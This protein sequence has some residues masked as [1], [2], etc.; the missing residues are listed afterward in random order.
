MLFYSFLGI[1]TQ[2]GKIESLCR[3]GTNIEHYPCLVKSGENIH[4]KGQAGCT[5]DHRPAN[6]YNGNYS[7]D[8]HDAESWKQETATCCPGHPHSAD[9]QWSS[10]P[11]ARDQEE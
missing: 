10:N 9:D 6:E 2:A 1:P 5:V 7:E 11:F 4:R 8:K 3:H